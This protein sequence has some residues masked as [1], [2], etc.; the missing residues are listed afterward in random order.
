MRGVV[1]DA[2]GD[3]IARASVEVR[4]VSS[5]LHRSVVSDEHGS[6]LV[7]DLPPGPC[8][9]TVAARGFAPASA[10][11]SVVLSTTLDVAAALSAVQ[12]S[13]TVRDHGSS[14]TEQP[15]DLTDGVHKGVISSQDLEALPL[16]A[17]SFANVAFLAPG[18][19]P[20]EPS[21]PDKGTDHCRINRGKLRAEQRTLG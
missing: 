13:L 8:G 6:F 2:S 18:T 20:V 3:P 4:M 11:V 1:Q 16:S 9:I 7:E 17:R 15:I 12:Q 19:E 5:H 10:E 14:V 21:D